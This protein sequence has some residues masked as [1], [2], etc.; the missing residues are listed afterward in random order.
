[1][2]LINSKIHLELSWNK[3]YVMSNIAGE[4]IF[5]ITTTKL[6]VLIVTLSTKVYEKLTEQL[7]EGFKRPVC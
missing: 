5:E 3:N 7:T 6:Y 4:T 2:P 1:M